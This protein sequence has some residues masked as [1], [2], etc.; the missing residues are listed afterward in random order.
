MS[1]RAFQRR[2]A[3]LED[4]RKPRPSPFTIWY[5]SIDGFLDFQVVPGIESG[6]LC[7]L[8]MIDVIAALRRWEGDG[9]YAT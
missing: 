3:K 8:D 2:V 4:V 6:S 5:G 1:L 9:Y 7:V